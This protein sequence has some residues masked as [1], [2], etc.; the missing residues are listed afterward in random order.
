MA[1]LGCRTYAHNSIARQLRHLKLPP[2]G[3]REFL[4][5]FFLHREE[6]WML[7]DVM[8]VLHDNFGDFEVEEGHTCRL[9]RFSS[10]RVAY[11]SFES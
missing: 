4:I 10:R 5:P 2:F 6:L 7:R 1:F 9:L 11:T 8:E 3:H